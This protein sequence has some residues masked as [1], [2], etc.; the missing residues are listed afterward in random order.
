MIINIEVNNR[1]IKAKKGETILS[2]LNRNGIKIP[3]LCHID[4]LDATGSC[5]MCVVEVDGK[6]N[7]IPAC[8][9][10][11]EAW[12]KIWTHS[13]K[14]INARKTI[15][16]LLLSNHPDDCLYCERNGNCELQNFAIELNVRERRFPGKKNKYKTDPSS[17]SLIRDPAK[18]I[19]CGRCVRM[20]DEILEIA[21]IDFIG[22]GNKSVIGPALNKPLNLSSCINCGQCIMVCPTGALYEKMHFRELQDALHNSNLHTVI[23]Y[24]PAIP[25]T[26][27]E[28]FGIKPGKDINGILNAALKK[29]GFDKVFETSYTVDVAIKEESE[30]LIQR[31]KAGGKLPMFTSC[32]PAWIKYLEQFIPEM[33]DN[34]ATCKSPQQILGALIN[35]FYSEIHKIPSEKI[36]TVSVMPCTAKKFEAQREQMTHKGISDVDAVLTTRELVKLIRLNGI[37]ISQCEPTLTD[38]PFRNRSGA[39]KIV[40]ISGGMMEAV[41][42]TVYYKLTG[43]ELPGYK[44]QE[45]RGSKG[46][47]E[48]SL[49]MGDYK[50]SVAV[51]NG[52][53]NIKLLLQDIAAGRKNYHFIEVMACPGGCINGGG[54]PLSNSSLAVK[55]RTKWL[56][57]SEETEP[58]R[59]AHKNSGV[60]EL[61]ENYLGEALS[62]K[63]QQLLHTSYKKREVLL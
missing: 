50:L 47:K 46:I 20:C 9:Y 30:E 5:R 36:Y 13:P 59:G 48:V 6:N 62:E 16:E 56:Y 41:I 34:L 28:E 12:M 11:I 2:A 15:V 8:S 51:V 4:G 23:Q 27:A 58:I 53:G 38:M 3:V 14:V 19:L 37:D 7:L 35:S 60:N 61:Y 54:Q 40:S 17:A 32:C 49:Q 18:C 24:S 52:M 55:N 45:A 57:D 22:R 1:P 42:R 39:G 43:K 44:L 29:I 33:I 31:L 63:C 25:I 10:P 26:I 21:A